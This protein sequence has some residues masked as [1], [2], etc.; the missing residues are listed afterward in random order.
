M[1]KLTLSECAQI[2]EV[3]AAIAVV[4]SLVYIGVGL[5]DNTAAIRSASVQAITTTSISGLIAQTT[6]ADLSRLRRAGDIDP[7]QLTEDEAYRYSTLYRQIWLSF[8]NV[9]LQ[10]DL[11]VIGAD[12]W[13]TYE[14]IICNE[15]AKVG[16]RTTWQSHA[17]VLDPKFVAAAEAC[18]TF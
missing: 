15:F 10:R 13:G 18:S 4:L 5:R 3:V 8:Q 14:R 17:N 7:T 9:F 11:G 12:L 16:V 1:R 6:N 2:A